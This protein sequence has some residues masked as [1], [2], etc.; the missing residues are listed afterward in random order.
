MA[1]VLCSGSGDEL[2]ARLEKLEPAAKPNGKASAAVARSTVRAAAAAKGASKA[3]APA[4]KR[5]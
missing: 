1:D 3:Q 4:K 5:R 2:K